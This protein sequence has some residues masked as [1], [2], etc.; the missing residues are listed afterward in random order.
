MLAILYKN[1]ENYKTGFFPEISHISYIE[2]QILKNR[3]IHI[4]VSV[5]D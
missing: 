1:K 4:L 2:K 3:D 5:A